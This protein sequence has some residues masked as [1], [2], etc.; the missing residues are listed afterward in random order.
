MGAVPMK[1]IVPNYIKGFL[2]INKY[3]QNDKKAQDI[4]NGQLHC[5]CGCNKFF[6]FREKWLQ[7]EESKV[8]EKAINALYEKYKK[9]PKYPIGN[10]NMF[11]ES[12][13]DLG[14]PKSK[15][16]IFY[17]PSKRPSI[18][19][20]D[21]TELQRAFRSCESVPTLI[22][23]ICSECGK[24]IEVFNSSKHGYDGLICENKREFSTIPRKKISKCK[25]CGSEER[26]LHIVFH[27]ED[28]EGIKEDLGSDEDIT[29]AFD[30]ITI[31]LECT[32]CKK[33]QKG[34]LDLE[35][36]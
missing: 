26:I 5:A 20:E 15:A 13:C 16:Y 21:I 2:E 7:S 33:V 11:G 23:A 6:V 24:E 36:M 4:T 31:D 9:D 22:L 32:N 25:K 12:V 17:C 10:G 1:N 34:Y 8:A 19:L 18:I 35:T 29:N 30:W 14:D 3:I 28:L 27:Y